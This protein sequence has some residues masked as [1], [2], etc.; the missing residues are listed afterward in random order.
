MIVPK[1]LPKDSN[2]RAHA[3]ARMLT[4]GPEPGEVMT[5]RSEVLAAAGRRGGKKGGKARAKNLPAVRRKAI[6][7]KAAKARWSPSSS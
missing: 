6:A 1:K 4:E 7:K 2:Q 5:E 3:I